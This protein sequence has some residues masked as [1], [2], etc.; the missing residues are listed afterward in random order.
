VNTIKI[1]I[2]S[3]IVVTVPA[4]LNLMTAY[5]LREQQ[6]W[7]EDE[8]KF[9]RTFIK[10][11]MK[12]IDI[13]ANYGVYALS[14]AKLVGESGKVWAFEPTEMTASCLQASVKANK[15]HHVELIQAGL[16]DRL[17]EAKLYTSPNSELNSL[18]K[19]AA[20]SAQYETIRLLTLDHCLQQHQ[21]QDIDFIKLDAEGEECNIL[22]E[23]KLTL[24][25]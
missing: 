25:S 2:A 10:P 21:W 7:F 15:F 16:S 8:I 6:D 11:G 19:E 9:I 24:T 4:A 3:D 23:A 12:V 20:S 13:G 14:M 18:S 17:G 22:K 1:K 5:V